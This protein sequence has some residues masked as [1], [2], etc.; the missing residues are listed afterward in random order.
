[1]NFKTY[2]RKV[3]SKINC[4]YSVKMR[5]KEDILMM[6]EERSNLN[7]CNDPVSLLG[8]PEKLANELI[9]NLD[10]YSSSNIDIKSHITILG[11]PLFHITNRKDVT[12]KGIIA[13]GLKS[14]GVISVGSISAGLIS[15]GAISIGIFSLGGISIALLFSV[16]GIAIAQSI[17][18]GGIA[19][20]QSLAIG[21]LAIAKDVT[22]G[23]V[24]SSKIMAYRESYIVPKNLDEGSVITFKYPLYMDDFKNRA[25]DLFSS[26]YDFLKRLIIKTLQ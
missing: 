22:V 15:F 25:M 12:A 23:S 10:D 3:V 14:V 24:T 21:G 26:K 17:A 19:I 4:S 8:T 6:L 11:L 16:G 7:D 9:E 20:A 1:M 13:I 5:L 18:I 2:V